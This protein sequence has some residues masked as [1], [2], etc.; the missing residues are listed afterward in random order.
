[1][2]SSP[3]RPNTAPAYL[4]MMTVLVLDQLTKTLV[5]INIPMNKSIPLLQKLFNDTFM[6][7]HVNNT[8]AAFSIGWG[9]DTFNR[10]FFIGTTI[11]AVAFILY[12]LYHS[13]HRLQ[14][15]SFGLV[16]GGAIGNMIDR[17][18]YGGVT[19][20]FSMDFP[21]IIMERFPIFNIADSSIFIAVCLLIIDM[22]FIRDKVPVVSELPPDEV[23]NNEIN[24]K[25]I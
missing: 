5:R 9:S 15:V 18:I 19:D 11:L 7:I 2:S 8:G 17:I 23:I 12:L 20:F 16:L 1:M 22:L 14:V 4:V 21:D 25:E 24:T 10:F 13:E 3:N 6:L